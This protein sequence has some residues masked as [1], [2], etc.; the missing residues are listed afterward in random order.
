MRS[1][2]PPAR[3]TAFAATAGT[4]LTLLAVATQTAVADCL[5]GVGQGRETPVARV[6]AAVAAAMALDLASTDCEVSSFV[7]SPRARHVDQTV[8]VTSR[9]AN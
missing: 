3:T 7:Q 2:P 6:M 5:D 8:E 4:I 1:V 9:G